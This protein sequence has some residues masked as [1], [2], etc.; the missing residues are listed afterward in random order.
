ME[1]SS[2]VKLTVFSN[3]KPIETGDSKST[4]LLM[5]LIYSKVNRNAFGNQA[6]FS[7]PGLNSMGR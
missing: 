6:F 1:I 5:V 3:E 7:I 4:L 2:F